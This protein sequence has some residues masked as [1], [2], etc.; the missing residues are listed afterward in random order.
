MKRLL[1]WL[2]V[3]ALTFA[4][5]FTVII[6]T[7]PTPVTINTSNISDEPHEGSAHETS[8]FPRLDITLKDT[9]LD[10]I[11]TDKLI[12]Y[13]ASA[14]LTL[15]N[16]SRTYEFIDIKGRGNSSWK[17]RKKPYQIALSE[18]SNLLGIGDY[19]TWVLLASA[20]DPSFLRIDL[21]TSL[22]YSLDLLPYKAGE[23]LDL[24]IDSTYLGLYY[25]VPKT[26][27]SLARLH[28][29]SGVLI[30]IDTLR[31]ETR[32]LYYE[33]SN[34]DFLSL[35][36]SVSDDKTVSSSAFASFIDTYELAISFLESG[37]YASA[38]TLLDV[39]SFARYIIFSELIGN[40]DAYVTSAYLYRDDDIDLIHAG[41]AWDFDLTFGNPILTTLF[42][43]PTNLILDYSTSTS[44][45]NLLFSFP[46]FKNLLAKTY[47]KTLKPLV[48]AILISLD[49]TYAYISKKAISD[50]SYW[51]D[52][53]SPTEAPKDN[54]TNPALE[55]PDTSLEESTFNSSYAEILSY[56]T[57]RLTFLDEYLSPYL[58]S[59][60]P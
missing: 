39:D 49:E 8:A 48:P 34:S 51:T 6:T 5:F 13:P 29:P 9:D 56:L 18:K 43:S 58:P 31:K 16:T 15:G 7:N 40:N 17:R 11:H 46:E 32:H 52:T 44:I 20:L 45:Y 33:A 1:R 37:D 21:S 27:T 3:I 23:Y 12:K 59:L 25:L 22:A 41:P 55:T 2:C 54:K 30:E 50:L 24:F 35:A 14:T 4:V 19:K 36:D 53:A 26:T 28:H 60:Y 47:F 10:T 38:S 57:S 42:T